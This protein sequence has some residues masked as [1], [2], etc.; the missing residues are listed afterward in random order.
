MPKGVILNIEDLHVTA[1]NKP[2]LQGISLTARSGKVYA[3]MGP[4][5]A[6]KST[7]AAVLAGQP[8]YT[9]TKGKVTFYDSDLLTLNPEQRAAKGLFIGFQHPPTIAGVR[10]INFLKTALNQI[11][12][13]RNLPELTAAQALIHIKKQVKMLG[14]E[15]SMLHKSLNENFSGG[16]KKRNELLQMAVLEPK[17]IILDEIDSGLDID[18]I[19]LVGEKLQHIRQNT[20]IILIT[21]Y[22]HLLRHISPDQVHILEQGRI[23]RSTKATVIDELLQKGY[24]GARLGR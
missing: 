18:G 19:Q 9:I 10:I 3:I 4:N 21:H 5:G 13:A 17:L 20:T 7:L 22:P 24:S 14:L 15:E 2:L 6:G 16:E 1:N 12:L 23:V 11:R 8:G